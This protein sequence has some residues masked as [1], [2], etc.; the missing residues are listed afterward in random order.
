MVPKERMKKTIIIT[1]INKKT[2]CIQRYQT[3]KDWNIIVVGDR[4]SRHI[5]SA[6][7][8]VFLSA[9]DQEKLGYKI[10]K[11]CP[12]DHYA[13]KNIGYLYAIQMGADVIYDTDDDN[14]PHKNW[15]LKPFSCKDILR[16]DR[17]FINIYRYFHK[18]K[19]WPRGFPLDEISKENASAVTKRRKDVKIA[20][21][22]GMADLD[23]DV[24]AIYRLLFPQP[25][26]FKSSRPVALD[27]WHYCPFNSQNTYWTRAAFPFLYLPSTVSFRFTDIL[28]GY[29]AQRL[30]WEL[31]HHLGFMGPT[32]YQKRNA[33]DLMRDF[34]DE[35]TCYLD[36]KPVVRLLDS[37]DLDADP[38]GSL[39]KVFHSL[40]SAKF[41]RP[42]EQ[43]LV[44]AWIADFRN[45]APSR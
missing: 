37:L 12:Y 30:F 28:R 31:D 4:K 27:K 20:V 5:R 32:V 39:K 44:N 45:C 29:I 23:P 25:V 43:R 15:G 16:S 21:W 2:E 1:T 36:V 7:N 14:I 40:V 6:G 10:V 17:K 9:K 13:R 34:K 8:L 22:Q 24:D 26:T 42:E 19:I 38:L 11:S 33:H 18:S 41:V 3:M 35:V